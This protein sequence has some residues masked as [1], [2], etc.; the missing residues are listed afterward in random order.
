MAGFNPKLMEIALSWC[1]GA[2]FLEV[3][4]MA[5]IYEGSIIRCFRRLDELLRELAE[6]SKSIGNLVA[7]LRNASNILGT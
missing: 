7:V 2:S 5:D 3:C 1:N 6:A 4:K